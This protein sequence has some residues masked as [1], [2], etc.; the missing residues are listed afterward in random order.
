MA[1][2]AAP[3]KICALVPVKRLGWAKS[4]L[5]PHLTTGERNCLAEAML[6]DVLD[7]LSKVPQ[8]GELRSSP[9]TPPSLQ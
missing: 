6:R 3:S 2:I 5:A 7:V 1:T 9:R 8:L 4:R